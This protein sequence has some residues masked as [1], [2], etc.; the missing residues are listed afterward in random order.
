MER[1]LERQAE[2]SA[3]VIPI[4][5]RDYLWH[6]APFGKLQPLP[7]DGKAVTSGTTR[8][9]RDKAWRQVAAGIERALKELGQT[10]D[11]RHL[12]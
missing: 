9:A 5:I 8:S 7:K 1:A 4:I 6:S 10:P 2:G 12:A 3:Q 11:R